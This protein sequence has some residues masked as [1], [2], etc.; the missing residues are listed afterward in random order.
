M[1]EKVFKPIEA[2]PSCHFH[3]KLQLFAMI[4]VDD[5]KLAGPKEILKQS[6]DM[7][8]DAVDIGKSEA[9]GLFLGCI[10]EPFKRTL[11]NGVTV[12][13]FQYNMEKF[14]IQR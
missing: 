4:Y 9:A 1:Q 14:S 11:P 5:F 13:G 6:W 3:D 10:H 7:V 2:W 8:C 12:R